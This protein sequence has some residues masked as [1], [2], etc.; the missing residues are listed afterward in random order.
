[1][2]GLRRWRTILILFLVYG[3]IDMDKNYADY[4]C[5]KCGLKFNIEIVEESQASINYGVKCCP[6][7]G[8]EIE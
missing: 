4:E 7:C 1:V 6:V 3:G 8:G 2:N 5:S